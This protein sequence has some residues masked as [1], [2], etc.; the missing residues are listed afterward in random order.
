MQRGYVKKVAGLPVDG[1]RETLLM[2]G[3]EPIYNEI[4]PELA[5]KALRPDD[6]LCI[7]GSLRILAQNREG[8]HEVL[9]LIRERG[10]SVMDVTTGRMATDDGAEM[11]IEAIREFSQAKAGHL[12]PKAAARIRWGKLE[13]ITKKDAR[14]IWRNTTAYPRVRDA[15]AAMTGWSVGSAYRELGKRSIPVGSIPTADE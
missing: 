15:L 1:Q 10:A 14:M 13:R 9:G 4:T 12:D 2:A 7:A 3:I 6:V 8:L 5:I 11:A